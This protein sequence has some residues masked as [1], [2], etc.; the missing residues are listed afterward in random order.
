MGFFLNLI[1]VIFEIGLL[2][3]AVYCLIYLIYHTRSMILCS[4]LVILF[5]LYFLILCFPLKVLEKTLIFIAPLTVLGCL[6]LFQHEIKRAL[7]YFRFGRKSMRKKN[8]EKEMISDLKSAIYSLSRKGIGAL[9][10]IKYRDSLDHFIKEGVFIDALFSHQLL[11]SLFALNTPLHDGAVIIEGNR[12][13]A[14]S[15]ILPLE[16][17]TEKENSQYGTRHRAAL[18]LSRLTE[19]LLIVVSEETGSV[20]IARQGIMHRDI[21]ENQCEGIL[22]SLFL[23]PLNKKGGNGISQEDLA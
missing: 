2:S 9:I 4:A 10:A 12:I 16:G 22:R 5:T 21:Q 8:P 20:S 15:V 18:S 6:I 11:E 14:A 19:S 1:S 3:G 17:T 23:D 7:A 13:M